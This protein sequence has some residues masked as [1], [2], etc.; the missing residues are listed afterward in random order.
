MANTAEQGSATSSTYNTLCQSRRE[1]RLLKLLP[2][3]LKDPISCELQVVSLDE[4]P[5]Y[6]PLSYVWG[7]P[8][9]VVVAYLH[10]VPVNVTVNLAAALRRLRKAEEPRVLW[11]DAL[12]INQEDSAERSQQVGLMQFIYQTHHVIVWLGDSP[13]SLRRVQQ[14]TPSPFTNTM[15]QAL[16]QKEDSAPSHSL[17]IAQGPTV[18]Q[19]SRAFS[20][21]RTLAAAEHIHHVPWLNLKD[22]L[23]PKIQDR[24]VDIWRSLFV[25][26]KLPYW[27]RMWTLQEIVLPING[28][29]HYGPV[30]AE[31]KSFL[32]IVLKIFRPQHSCCKEIISNLKPEH[33]NLLLDVCCQLW[34]IHE[35][36]ASQTH[37]RRHVMSLLNIHRFRLAH[38]PRDKIY[39]LVGLIGDHRGIIVVDYC[40][41]PSLIYL[42]FAASFIQYSGETTILMFAGERGRNPDLPT[43]VPVRISTTCR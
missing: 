34:L 14:N 25:L 42:Q 18:K 15:L 23:K 33:Y 8:S 1:I 2:G 43:W 35:T 4:K 13:T 16:G 32:G 3:H 12:C 38:D 28:E 40:L 5:T 27:Q 30:S 36:L 10:N 29:I 39:S 11:V 9:V 24:Y 17:E 31:L 19:A 41:E 6:E 21:V 7:D 20:L 37:D 26:M 22:S